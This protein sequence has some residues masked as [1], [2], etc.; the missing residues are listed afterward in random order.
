MAAI[1][2]YSSLKTEIQ[3]FM[4]KSNLAGDVDLFIDLCESELA[5]RLR[6]ARMLALTE[7]GNTTTGIL[8]LDAA[9]FVRF[10]EIQSL[11]I[12]V[13]G[14]SRILNYVSPDLYFTQYADR[15]AGTPEYYTV[16]NN[17]IY[18]LPAPDEA[19]DYTALYYQRTTPLDDTNTTNW[20][21][22]ND[23]QLYLYGSL[24]HAAVFIRDDQ[25]AQEYM[26]IFEKLLHIHNDRQK[27]VRHGGTSRMISETTVI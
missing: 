2:D 6:S 10:L 17:S 3:N 13:N 8:D 23:P 9:P 15:I 19:R 26:G 16:M 18:M 22:T 21:L 7:N 12:D 14:R 5:T 25:R 20:V 11:Q 4:N 27:R 24:Y 1:L